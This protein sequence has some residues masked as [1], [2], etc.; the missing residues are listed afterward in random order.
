MTSMIEN[1]RSTFR[2]YLEDAIKKFDL[3]APMPY[4]EQTTNLIHELINKPE[5]KI[6]FLIKKYPV[7][8]SED[9][10]SKEAYRMALNSNHIFELQ[11]VPVGL[12]NKGDRIITL[13]DLMSNNEICFNFAKIKKILNGFYDVEAHAAEICSFNLETGQLKEPE[14]TEPRNILIYPTSLLIPDTL[15]KQM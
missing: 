6:L 12:I 1:G 7:N 13:S 2:F 5:T 4:I 3:A 8:Q 9:I 10:D 11:D 14:Y 15:L